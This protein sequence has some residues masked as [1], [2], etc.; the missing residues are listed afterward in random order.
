MFFNVGAAKT[1]FIAMI[2]T[3]VNQKQRQCEI[4]HFCRLIL[5]GHLPIY[6]EIVHV[7]QRKRFYC[8]PKFQK[9]EEVLTEMSRTQ[10]GLVLTLRAWS[11]ERLKKNIFSS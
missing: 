11:K 2:S 10:H 3:V 1:N 9:M 6:V 5:K 7:D 8:L 4:W